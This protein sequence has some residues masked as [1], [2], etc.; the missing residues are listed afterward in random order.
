[1]KCEEIQALEGAYL[2]SELDAAATAEVA[3]H[4]KSCPECARLFAEQGE[5]NSWLRAALSKGERSPEV[6]ERAERAVR[7]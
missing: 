1:M 4:L 3:G 5:L 6:W 2:D 7:S